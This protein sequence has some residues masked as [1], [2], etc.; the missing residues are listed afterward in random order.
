MSTITT[1][2]ERLDEVTKEQQELKDRLAHINQ[3]AEQIKLELEKKH[4]LPERKVAD[5]IRDVAEQLQKILV[6]NNWNVSDCFMESR[7]CG[8]YAGKGLF[9]SIKYEKVQWEILED[10]FDTLV[11]VPIFKD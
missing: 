6:D 3:V 5:A 2:Q 1:L 8:K 7:R 9:L 4:I 10:E 11:L